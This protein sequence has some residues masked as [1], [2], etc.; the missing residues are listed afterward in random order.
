[1]RLAVAVEY[2]FDRTPD[3]AVWSET[4]Y[5]YAFWRRYLEVYEQVL[6]IARI[7][8]VS[9]AEPG[10]TRADG[11]RVSFCAVPHYIG[12]SEYVT[13][14]WRVRRA[15]RGAI[16]PDDAVI[17]RA[18]GM[19]SNLVFKRLAANHQ[20]FGMEVIGDPYDT[21]APGTIRHPL[22]PF[23][24]RWFTNRLK[25]QCASACAAAYVT[26]HALQ[27]RYPAAT[28]AFVTN[29]S[30][31]E[32]PE[33]AFVASPRRLNRGSSTATLINVGAFDT[34]YK[35]QDVLVDAV[36][37]CV[38]QGMDLQLNL[39][40]SGRHR[41][42]IEARVRMRRL[43]DRVHFWGRLPAGEAVRA[44]L[45][46]ADLFVLPSRAEG[47]PRAMIEAMARAL[48]C[49]GSTAGGIP[50][51]L[52]PEDMV[53]PDDV[54]ALGRKIREIEIDP[55]R[56]AQMSARNLDW[57]KNYHDSIL[58]ERRVAFYQHLRERTEAWLRTS[59]DRMAYAH[60]EEY[61]YHS[62]LMERYR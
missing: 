26:E 5:T 38:R 44:K 55:G 34:L 19:V 25:R 42:D 41:P 36:A 56:M 54:A 13:Q 43:E 61:K 39:V 40:G 16:A 15:L 20:P 1:M 11:K 53:P 10:W 30:S 17:L 24:R 45:D 12:P 21:F 48:P 60:M 27:R 37:M 50:E 33:T 46:Q 4:M 32:L 3:G 31:V 23:F 47:L 18:P 2:R 22:R 51:L 28:E 49:I 8:E 59:I 29:Y 7:R 35:A 6:V 52:P 57:A 14:A 9:S 58:H 62:E